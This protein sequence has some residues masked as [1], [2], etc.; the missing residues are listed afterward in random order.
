MQPAAC[1][2][3]LPTAGE[4]ASSSLS[5]LAFALSYMH[6][7]LPVCFSLPLP[8]P[9]LHVA[10]RRLLLQ[11]DHGYPSRFLGRASQAAALGDLAE[12]CAS[13]ARAL[14]GDAGAAGAA[15]AEEFDRVAAQLA[16]GGSR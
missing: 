4:H 1:D 7:A 15:L 9:P 5:L 6:A 12:R 11:P 13:E 3:L 14:G 16:D 2:L 8:P 10:C